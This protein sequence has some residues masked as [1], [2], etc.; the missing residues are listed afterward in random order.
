MANVLFNVFAL[1]SVIAAAGVV[2]NRNAVN[3]SMCLLLSLVGVAG[4][5]VALDAYL[6]AFLLLL[7]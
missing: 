6:L 1:L 3:A 7:V 4:L 2:L 5:F